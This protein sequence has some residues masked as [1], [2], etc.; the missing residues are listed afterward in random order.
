MKI[1][2]IT[3]IFFLTSM[4]AIWLSIRKFRKETM[5]IRSAVV[6]ISMWTAI[7]VCSIFPSILDFFMSLG[8]MGNRMFFI[9]LM[10]VF[11]LLLLIFDLSSK[12]E[13]V[14]RD[15]TLLVQELTI[16]RYKL[17]NALEKDKKEED[18]KENSS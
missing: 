14:Q 1:T 8:Q 16:L 18:G 3:V 11:F 13:K 9:L 15:S 5:S 7:G 2:T 12:L 6:W 17:D 10:A 4:F